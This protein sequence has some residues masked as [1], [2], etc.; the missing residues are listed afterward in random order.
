MDDKVALILLSIF[1]IFPL[2]LILLLG[3][4]SIINRHIC[5]KY[6][7]NMIDVEHKIRTQDAPFSRIV[8][9][10]YYCKIPTCKRVGCHHK[11]EPKDLVQADYY[12][13][14]SMPSD[15]WDILRKKGYLVLD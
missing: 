3:I 15:D 8:C 2:S 6:G 4:I 11:E 9:T 1:V 7:H 5:K 14:V 12:N 13:S 10:D